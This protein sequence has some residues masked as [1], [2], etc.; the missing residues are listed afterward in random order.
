MAQSK[1]QMLKALAATAKYKK[2]KPAV[3]KQLRDAAVR[4]WNAQ[5][6]GNYSAA[7][8]GGK[9]N[10]S[11]AMLEATPELLNIF[12]AAYV[13]EW[14]EDRIVAEIQNTAWFRENSVS[15]KEAEKVRLQNP[16]EY[17]AAIARRR[18]EIEDAA[19]QLGADVTG[20]ELDRLAKDA[21]YGNWSQSQLRKYVSAEIDIQATGG[22]F[23]EAGKTEM[24][25]RK[26][27]AAN[28]VE[29][30]DSWFR[31]QAR[32]SLATGGTGEAE[33]LIREN[34]ANTYTQYADSIRQGTNL[35]VLAGNYL[36]SLEKT[37]DLQ[38]GSASLLDPNVKRA[39]QAR[40]EQGKPVTKPLWQFE[41]DLRRDP[42]WLTTKNGAETMAN[43][44][45]GVLQEWGFLN[46][47]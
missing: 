38:D 22:L 31:D 14:T 25:L 27:A 19:V 20:E 9:Y 3:K 28:G 10:Y 43:V 23:G 5:Q 32:K 39:L 42:K 36:R 1:T 46:N 4:K 41:E 21:L 26:L 33:R 30:Q 12:K 34:A 2:A 7:D 35:N 47:G 37:Y 13:S 24:E 6:P 18:A 16:G 11:R 15:W 40:D 29:L 17:R 44:A 45:G 8:M